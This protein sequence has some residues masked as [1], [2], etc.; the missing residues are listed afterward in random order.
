MREKNEKQSKRCWTSY[1][2]FA[3]FFFSRI[4]FLIFIQVTVQWLIVPWSAPCE[5]GFEEASA[6]LQA[7]FC[8]FTIH[9]FTIQGQWHWMNLPRILQHKDEIILASA[10]SISVAEI[11][12]KNSP[13]KGKKMRFW[14]NSRKIKKFISGYFL[15]QRLWGKQKRKTSKAYYDLIISY[16]L[17]YWNRASRNICFI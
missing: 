12:S 16:L 8:L 4:R 6:F 3:L 15:H 2:A 1:L 10:E 17:I 9:I 5:Q 14:T 13:Y 7:F 11:A